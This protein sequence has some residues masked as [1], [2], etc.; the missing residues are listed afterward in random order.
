MSH[1]RESYVAIV[2]DSHKT[3]CFTNILMLGQEGSENAYDAPEMCN[4]IF[5]LV[6]FSKR[7]KGY[8][9]IKNFMSLVH[10]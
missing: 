10:T 7:T 6:D 9:V 8:P 3:V 5:E 4:C 2:P 1:A